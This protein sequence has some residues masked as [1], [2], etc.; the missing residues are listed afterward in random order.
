M[1]Y[2]LTSVLVFQPALPMRGVTRR[3][4]RKIKRLQF[5]PALPMRGVTNL[6]DNIGGFF[7]ISTRTPHAGSDRLQQRELLGVDEISTRTPHAG[8][9]LYTPQVLCA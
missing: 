1:T 5:Q 8:S 9:D 3:A 4:R 6:T 2:P 7:S